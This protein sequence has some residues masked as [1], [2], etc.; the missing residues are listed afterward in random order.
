MVESRARRVLLVEPDG[1]LARDL[2]STFGANDFHVKVSAS[3]HSAKLA[4]R[5]F[6]PD[7]VLLDLEPDHDAA[8]GLFDEIRRTQATPIVIVS[9][10]GGQRDIVAALER[11]ADD[12]ITKPIAMDE[13]LARVRAGL[14]RL[15]PSTFRS[16]PAPLRIG[17]LE[18]D[19]EGRR[20]ARDDLRVALTQTECALLGVFVRHAD[21]LLTDRMLLETVW[22]EASPTNRH[23]LQVYVARLRRKLEVDPRAPVYLVS[24]SRAG[25]R[26]VTGG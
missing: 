16:A 5:S 4:C 22:G 19:L 18:I 1:V 8:W 14:R 21:K 2:K 17:E 25:Y 13:L 26:L 15:A 23:L 6:E 11:G 3:P 10:L 9:A 7:L 20:V 24:E 12:Y